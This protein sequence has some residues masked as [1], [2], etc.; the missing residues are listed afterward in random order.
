MKGYSNLWKEKNYVKVMLANVITRLG[1][2]IDTIA[3]SWLVYVVTGSTVLTASIYG[4]NMIPNL[5]I[6]L[7]SG[8]IC[9]YAN[10]KIVMFICDI[11]RCLCV[12][13]IAFLFMNHQLET[14][15]LF[16]ITFINSSFEAFRTPCE[17]SIYPKILSNDNLDKGIA[18]KQSLV[19][20]A[21]FIGLIIAPI[22]IALFGLQ[23]A[24][25]MDALS[26]AICGFIILTMY[27]SKKITNYRMTFNQCFQ[28]LFDGF[29]YM[30]KDQFL[31]K[32]LIIFCI[33]NALFVPIQ[34]FQAAYMKDILQMNTTGISI[35]SISFLL[36]N[37]L[38]SPF[39]PKLKNIFKGRK[40]IVYSIIFISI[41]MIIYT[42]LPQFSLSKRYIMLAIVSLMIGASI[43]IINYP[44][45]LTLY[46]RIEMKYQS[47]IQSI[48]GTCAMAITPISAFIAGLISYYLS[49]QTIY[50]F[51][52]IGFLI[53]SIYIYFNQLFYIFNNY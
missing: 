51:C 5:T 7:V 32:I 36:G 8:V 43:C 52:A 40:L 25:L 50:L 12:F 42:I 39:L 21:N 26:F 33:V 14:W 3:F 23:G 20:G 15:H 31:T 46:K 2:G 28:D 45:Q 17:A 22:C 37:V 24:L 19:S 27:S 1:D 48:C 18:F 41:M 35:F 47:R 30:K 4:V 10:E 11:G 13:L 34:S 6:G 9:Q 49:I 53:S 38:I 29:N 16:V 44:I